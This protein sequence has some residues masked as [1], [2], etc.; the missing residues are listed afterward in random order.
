MM[1][2]AKANSLLT[3]DPLYCMRRW[4][5]KLETKLADYRAQE[6]R[7]TQELAILQANVQMLESLLEDVREILM[8]PED[9]PCRLSE[10]P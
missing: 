7:A 4:A 3:A 8:T 10:S 2:T 1:V 9:K 6:Q 5:M